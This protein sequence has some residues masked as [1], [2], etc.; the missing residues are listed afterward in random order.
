MEEKEQ[1]MEE[2]LSSIRRILSTEDGGV[3]KEQTIE[4]TPEM[5]VNASPSTENA[6]ENAAESSTLVDEGVAQVSMKKLTQLAHVVSEETAEK[7]VPETS[8]EGLV[9]SILTP[10][11]KEWLDA[12]LPSLIE[13]VVQKEVRRIADKVELS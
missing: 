8:L 4:L 11:L 13:R 6:K 12:N 5:R 2:I 7:A 9:R 10:Y 3:Q 1:S